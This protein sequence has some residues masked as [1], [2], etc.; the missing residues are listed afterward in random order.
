MTVHPF[1]IRAS[2]IRRGPNAVAFAAVWATACAA[3]GGP[4]TSVWTVGGPDDT[5]GVAAAAL[6]GWYALADSFEDR[7]EVR[8]P[9]G[10]LRATITKEQI[11]SLVPWMTLDGSADGVG[12]VAFS[13]SGRLLF[14]AVH[15]ANPAGD[16]QPSDAVLRYD[17]GTG[18]LSVFA[19]VEFGSSDA[20]WPHESLTHHAGRLFVGAAGS[21]RVYRAR[22]NDASGVLL[23]SSATS[24]GQVVGGLTID[25]TSR[26]LYWSVGDQLF[27][28]A[29]ADTLSPTLVGTLPAAPVGL[30]YAE[31]YGN[32]A[33]AGLYVLDSTAPALHRVWKVTPSQARGQQA[34]S[35]TIYVAGATTAHD[36]A[37]TADGGLLIATDEDAIAVRD[38]NDTRLGFE[39]WAANEFAQVV[40]FGRS[41]VTTAP[42][43]GGGPAGWVIDADV[44]TG[45]TRFHPASPD[46]AA[47]TV[48]LMMMNDHVNGDATAQGTVRTI[49]RRYA[50]RASDGIVPLRS[51][52]GIYWH[53]LDPVNGG[54]RAGWGDGYATMSTMKIVLAAARARAFYP[55][56]AEIRASA[57]AIICGVTNWDSYFSLSGQMYLL[58]NLSG[59]PL[60]PSASSGFHE[61]I[62][63][64]DQ[65]GTYGGTFGQAISNLWMTRSFW[66]TASLVTGKP[67]TGQASGQFL[68][69]FIT[70]YPWLLI[71][72]FRSDPAW[73]V[74]MTNFRDSH[75]AW[76]DD[77]G[78]LWATVFSAGTTAAQW[79]GYHADSLSDH[80]GDVATFTS[81]LATVSGDGSG[82]RLPEAY[83]AYQAYRAGARQSFL[84]GASILYRRSSV[85]PSYTPDSAGLPDVA[86]GALGLAEL[87]LPGSVRAVLTGAYPSCASCP[88]DFNGDGFLDFFDYDEYVAAFEQGDPMT[89]FNGDGFLDFFDYDAF[90]TAF[91]AGC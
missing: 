41:L 13:D 9:D 70:L 2:L 65:A 56:D 30:A 14:I 39:A 89:D 75:A 82:A 35:P 57:Q 47:W 44:A 20:A 63:F 76:T 28:A 61:G 23:S 36:I 48:L 5:S 10:T 55:D 4:Q 37:A 46:G 45:N 31:H 11:A 25:R 49:L 69:G 83:A 88:P 51:A 68:P 64:T 34:L 59:G 72:A 32:A 33:D 17:T 80:P 67:V 54:A 58:A 6:S 16:G 77:Q 40:T 52:D 18:A 74:N 29:A 86:I 12:A 3:M 7:V 78:P 21:L 26:L 1:T 19:R 27:R 87:L 73:R 62:L 15:D 53:W 66:P 8:Q 38:T 60:L 90:V 50:G 22:A 84:G 42:G 79:G 91:E 71:D 43:A 81:L 85:T 24:G